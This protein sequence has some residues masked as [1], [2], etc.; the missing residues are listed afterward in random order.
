MALKK[1]VGV[2]APVGK[3]L[4][5]VISSRNQPLIMIKNISKS[6][7]QKVVL[8][9]VSFD[10]YHKDIF[11]IIG[12]S[13]SGKTTMF[14]LLAG[15]LKPQTGDVLV[16]SEIL[17]IKKKN[18]HLDYVSVF[19]NKNSVKKHF[20]F[21]TQVPSFYE[22]LTAEEN[23]MMYCSLYGLPKKK[24]KE[25]TSNLLK[26]VDL[27]SDK[28][29]LGSEMSGGMQRRLDIACALVHEPKVLFLDE[30]TSD[31]DPVMRKQIWSL[32]KGINEK[33]TTIVLASHILEEVESLCTKV[34]ILHNRRIL[35]HGT[36]KELKSLFR[37]NRQIKVELDGGDYEPIKRK[38]K[39]EKSVERVI[40]KDGRLVIVVPSDE[41][42]IR[43]VIR[44]IDAS[45][46]GL[47]SLDVSDASLTEIFETLTKKE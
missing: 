40:E 16:Q 23:L 19:R 27:S 5:T 42:V 45:T 21:A 4:K 35:G 13:G 12:M 7:R 8:K 32:I 34:A 11:G 46:D 43:K 44:T 15:V 29:T 36:L 30:P 20:G 41:K 2:A 3:A 24:A 17:G 38:L 39:S 22:H 6:Y 25:M 9:D 37:R 10:I 31:L 28:D 1:E 47:I 26:L 14:Q 33:G 18:D